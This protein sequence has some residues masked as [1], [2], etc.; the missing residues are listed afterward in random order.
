MEQCKYVDHRLI[1]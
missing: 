1:E